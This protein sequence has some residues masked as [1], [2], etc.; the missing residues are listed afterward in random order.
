METQ[1][2]DGSVTAQLRGMPSASCVAVTALAPAASALIRGLKV[3]DAETDIR[4]SGKVNSLAV[5][6][7]PVQEDVV[8]DVLAEDQ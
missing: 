6:E 5:V 4:A 3:V 2:P 7:Q 8:T 1:L